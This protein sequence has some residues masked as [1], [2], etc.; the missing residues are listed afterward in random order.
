M[1]AEKS[2]QAWDFRPSFFF[3]MEAGGLTILPPD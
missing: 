1:E 3:G 2:S